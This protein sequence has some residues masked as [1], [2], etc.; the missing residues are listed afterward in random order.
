MYKS[1]TMMFLGL[2]FEITGMIL[3]G[4]FLGRNVG[5]YLEHEDLGAATG[6]LLA[7]IAWCLHVLF[8]TRSHQQKK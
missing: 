5:R 2:G 1:K 4:L 6:C 7:F 8:L 3:V